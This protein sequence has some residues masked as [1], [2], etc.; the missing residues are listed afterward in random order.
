MMNVPAY[1]LE[2]TS[3]FS[4]WPGDH[5]TQWNPEPGT[6][7]SQVQATRIFLLIGNVRSASTST[8][9]DARNAIDAVYPGGFLLLK[10]AVLSDETLMIQVQVQSF[11]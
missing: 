8:L 2:E 6:L 7:L 5:P 11:Q 1:V 4:D 3:H 9:L 10:T